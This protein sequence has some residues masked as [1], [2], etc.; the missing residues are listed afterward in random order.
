[1][2]MNNDKV[3]LLR[4][5]KQRQS[6]HRLHAAPGACLWLW[7]G[8]TLRAVSLRDVHRHDPLSAIVA[9]LRAL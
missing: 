1:M 4:A 7:H 5:L 2:M 6:S 8:S 9:L 3:A